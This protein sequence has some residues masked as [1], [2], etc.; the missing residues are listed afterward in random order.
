MHKTGELVKIPLIPQAKSLIPNGQ[1]YFEQQQIFKILS[2][3]PT[4]RY[5]KEIMLTAEISKHISFHC[6]RHTFAT[7]GLNLG[8]PMSLISELMGHTDQ[9]NTEIYAQYDTTIKRKEMEKWDNI[10]FF[11]FFVVLLRL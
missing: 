8:I 4:N 3:Q 5:L 9:K 10:C 1:K 2:D 7:V 6:S 11:H